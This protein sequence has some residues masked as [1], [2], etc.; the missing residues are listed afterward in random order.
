MVSQEAVDIEWTGLIDAGEA[1]REAQMV[2]RYTELAAL[3]ED[4]RRERLK[5]MARAEYAL[6]DDKLRTFTIARM[7][8]WLQLEEEQAQ[9]VAG[10]YDA[11]MQNMPATIAMRRVALVQTLALEFSAE[12]EARLRRLMP[13]IF[14]GAPSRTTG[15]GDAPP[16]LPG[17]RTEGAA[18]SRPF[19]AFW[20]K[21]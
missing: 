5:A 16:P 17:S 11:V 1:E 4:D 2:A 6:P 12:D 3:S 8:S 19:W 20:R 7:R 18:R 21:G 14:A 15:L 10:S 9:R 13:R